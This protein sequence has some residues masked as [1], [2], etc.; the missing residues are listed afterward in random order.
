MKEPHEQRALSTTI[1]LIIW[2]TGAYFCAGYLAYRSIKRMLR[3]LLYVDIPPQLLVGA[4]LIVSGLVFIF[5][6]LIVERVRDARLESGLQ[7]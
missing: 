6:S 7:D 4:S 5:I 3:A 1:G 2:R